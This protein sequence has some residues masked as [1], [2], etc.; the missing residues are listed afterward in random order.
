M[1]A[2]VRTTPSLGLRIFTLRTVV[3]VSESDIS[4]GLSLA[5]IP[6]ST[7]NCSPLDLSSE[8]SFKVLTKPDAGS[9]ANDSRTRSKFDSDISYLEEIR[10]FFLIK[11]HH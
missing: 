6:I 5:R 8:M 1:L 9:T 11:N 4:L 7:G 10:G 3:A 2:T